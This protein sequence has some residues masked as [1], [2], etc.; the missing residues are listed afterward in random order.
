MTL[1]PSASVLALIVAAGLGAVAAAATDS[2]THAPS[3]ASMTSRTAKSEPLLAKIRARRLAIEAHLAP[4]MRAWL[5]GIGNSR[6]AALLDV[7]ETAVQSIST[8]IRA[9]Y[10]TLNQQQLDLL[11]F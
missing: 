6:R 3:A 4:P 7:P 8:Q 2:D 10:P 11:T 1:R 5:T 9:Q